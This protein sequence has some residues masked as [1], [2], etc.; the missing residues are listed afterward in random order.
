MY[1]IY[2]IPGKKIGCTKNPK[3][4][5]QYRQ[6]YENYEILETHTNINIASQREIE[7]QKEYGYKR[8]NNLSYVQTLKICKKGAK[9]SAKAKSIPIL[10]YEFNTGNFIGEFVSIRKAARELNMPH[11][12][13]I[14]NLS[15]VTGQE[16]GYTFEYKVVK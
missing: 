6:R 13:I 16:R 12:N 14:R 5:I 9:N 2:H 8:D 1:Y 15:G 7:L 10:C 11:S 4:R 3:H